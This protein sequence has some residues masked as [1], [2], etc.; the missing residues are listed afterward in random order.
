MT[1]TPTPSHI[2]PCRRMGRQC[3]ALDAT[4][5]VSG[6]EDG[7][8]TG[9][10]EAT[11][12]L[13]HTEHIS[14]RKLWHDAEDLYADATLHVPCRFYR[15]DGLGGATCRAHGFAGPAP[16][17]PQPRNLPRQLGGDRFTVVEQGKLRP[18]TLSHPPRSLHVLAGGGHSNPCDGAPCKTSDHRRGA[19]CCRDLQVEVMCTRRQVRLESLIRSRKSP[20]L[21]K[22]ERGGDYSIDV[23][24]ISACGYLEPG[25]V[26]CTLHGR[27]RPDGR[28]AKP[29]LCFDWPPKGKG[30]HP[31]CVFGPKRRRR[32]PASRA[33][34]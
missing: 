13:G 6:I 3:H 8:A 15:E 1:A 26:A 17:R 30:L 14:F 7:L 4:L 5:R 19:A 21:C 20:Y 27:K 34:R 25:G 28:G 11:W 18:L 31:G 23:E 12:L 2:P 29:D 9:D 24:M 10:H 33:S 22:I 32:P 16:R